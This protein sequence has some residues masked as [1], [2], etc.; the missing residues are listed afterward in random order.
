MLASLSNT[1]RKPS[2]TCTLYIR[3]QHKGRD[4]EYIVSMCVNLLNI[5]VL[6]RCFPKGTVPFGPAHVPFGQY[7]E[8][9]VCP[10]ES[11]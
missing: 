8:S 1:I 2:I 7:H 6:A 9:Q 3:D 4:N 10:S 5:S 11:Y